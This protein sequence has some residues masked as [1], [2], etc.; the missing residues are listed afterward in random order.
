LKAD[1]FLIGCAPRRG[2]NCPLGT[3]GPDV[4]YGSS[5]ILATL[6]GGKQIVMA[7]QKSG[8][9]SGLDP[10]TGAKVWQ[11][12]VGYGSLFGGV[13]WG[14]A[15]DNKALYVAI[16]DGAAPRDKARAGLYALDRATGRLLRESLAPTVPCGWSHKPCSPD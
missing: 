14:M 3:L 7:G 2:V 6:P 1:N 13:E 15:A 12:Q 10:D 16:S 11:T 4:D 8:L 5:P 9:V